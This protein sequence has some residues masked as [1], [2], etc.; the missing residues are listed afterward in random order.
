LYF[1]SVIMH[2]IKITYKRVLVSGYSSANLIR[3]GRT[4]CLEKFRVYFN[5]YNKMAF[6]ISVHGPNLLIS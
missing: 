6:R 1:L 2:I 4:R 3:H 5:S